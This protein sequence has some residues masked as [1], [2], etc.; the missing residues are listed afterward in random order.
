MLL[1]W[2]CFATSIFADPGK[3][4]VDLDNWSALNLLPASRYL[5]DSGNYLTLDNV[6]HASGWMVLGRDQLRFGMEKK[7]VWL[8]IQFR[9]AGTESRNA[10]VEFNRIIDFV[11]MRLYENGVQ[12]EEWHQGAFLDHPEGLTQTNKNVFSFRLQPGWDYRLVVRLQGY[13][14]VT[15]V[16]TLYEEKSFQTADEKILFLFIAYAM[17]VAAIVFYNMAVY[18]SSGLKVFVYH[19]MYGLAVLLMQAAQYGY[20]DSWLQSHGGAYGKGVIIIFACSAAYSLVLGLFYEMTSNKQG[21][22]FTRALQLIVVGNLLVIWVAPFV[23]LHT[24]LTLLAVNVVAGV[25]FGV[26]HGVHLAYRQDARFW[27]LLFMLLIF[28]PSGGLLILSRFGLMDDTFWAEYGLVMTVVAEMLLLS[29][30]LFSRIRQMRLASWKARFEDPCNHLP[31]I[32][33]LQEQLRQLAEQQAHALSYCW[34]AGLDKME[35]ARGSG[36]RN[37]YLGSLATLLEVHLQWE[38]FA[39]PAIRRKQVMPSVFYCENNTLGL[40]TLPLD[41]HEHQRLQ[42][43][44]GQVFD[45]AKLQYGYN[46]D[47]STVLASNNVVPSEND[48]EHTIQNVNVALSQCIQVGKSLLLYN[49]D[50][51]HNERR[52]IALLHDFDVALEQNQFYLQWQPQFDPPGKRLLG[53]EALVRWRHPCY[54]ELSPA[55]FIPLLEQNSMI[56]RLSLWVVGQ[57]FT[58]TSVFFQRFPHLDVSINLSVYDLMS[59]RFFR[60]LDKLL[61]SVSVKI[62]PKII[63]EVTESVHMEDNNRVRQAVEALQVRGFRVSI[64]D[65]GAGY[66]SFGYLQTLPVNELKID[67]RYTDNCHEASS[68][69]IIRSIID[70]ATRLNMQIVVEGIEEQQQQDLFMHWGVHRLQGWRLGKPATQE[71]ILTLY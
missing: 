1:L 63:M 20:L 27:Q 3:V 4:S 54:G 21:R 29:G 58:H 67:K 45:Q 44:I 30:V 8:D 48:V 65:F 31:N 17:V 18:L 70:L 46:L 37:Q 9:A 22:L 52:Q 47:M 11:D 26:L 28:L 14:T 51:G 68:Q 23:A 6:L 42:Q 62:P 33:A 53:L 32:L 69:A 40:L 15:G 38:G 55:Q 66:A 34:I 59:D 13:N 12:R 43:L 64:D 7:P 5:L 24:G 50:V 10:V 36:F 35:I 60:G 25:L 19:A 39:L 49:D 2:W 71:E 41:N 16:V 61:E 56:T 57:V